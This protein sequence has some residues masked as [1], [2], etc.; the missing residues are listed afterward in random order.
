MTLLVRDEADI[1]EQN[2]DFHLEQ[3]VDHVLVVDNGSIDGTR[4]ILASCTRSKPVTV[5]DEPGRNYAQS[6]WVTQ[7]VKRA[8]DEFEADW[9]FSND[10]DEFWVAPRGDLKAELSRTRAHMLTCPRRNMV[11]AYDAPPSGAHW[12]E[13]LC[14][15]VQS[16]VPRVCLDDFYKDTLPCPYFY[17]DLQPKVLFCPEGLT[18]VA[19]GNHTAKFDRPVVQEEADVLIYHF[20]I[21]SQSQ[22]ERKILQGG[23]AF[24]ENP[25]LPK[26]AGWHWRRW[27][28][29]ILEDGVISA[30]A[31]ALPTMERLTQDLATGRVIKTPPLKIS[32]L[33]PGAKDVQLTQ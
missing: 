17:L 2:I 4:D 27:Y 5:I 24:L 3:G 8:R 7:A 6:H 33:G 16:P 25:K 31:D 30:L 23:A 9:V 21:R 29:M 28:R 1:I 19:M 12:S 14:Y 10:A 15:R 11:F 13:R 22:F 20:P 26:R 32:G 18:S